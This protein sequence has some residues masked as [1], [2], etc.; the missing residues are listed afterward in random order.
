M[1]SAGTWKQNQP[2]TILFVM[3]DSSGSEVTGL[4]SAFTLQLSKAGGSFFT[5]LGTKS[6]VGLGWYKYL[7]TSAEADTPGPV[8]VVVT[9][10]STIQQNLEYVCETRVE[11]A[12]AFTYTL[13]STAGGSPP[14]VG[15]EILIYT[16]A[17]GTNFVWSGL[18]DTFGVARD[19]NGELPRLDPGAYFFFAYK[20][21]FAFTNPDSETVS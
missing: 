3:V 20:N 8:A 21:G 4:G 17:G 19:I 6:E 11:T 14:I 12:V 9:H 2:N 10:A 15:A 5:G 18:T 16:D 1:L 7:S 13:T